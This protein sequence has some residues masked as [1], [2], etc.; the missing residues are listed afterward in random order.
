MIRKLAMRDTGATQ[1]LNLGGSGDE[2][3]GSGHGFDLFELVFL[4]EKWGGGRGER[5][6]GT[7]RGGRGSMAAAGRR[8]GQAKRTKEDTPLHS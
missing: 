3:C 8:E 6:R 5:R 4:A 7:V 2:P 1:G